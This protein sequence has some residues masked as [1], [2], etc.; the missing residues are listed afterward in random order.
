MLYDLQGERDFEFIRGSD[1]DYKF[2]NID[3]SLIK[4]KDII[5]FGSATAF[6]E[7]ELKESYFK[8]LEYAEENNIFISFYPNY[9]DLLIKE[10]Y[11]DDYIENCKHFI[12]KSDFIKFSLEE[13]WLIT[14][15]K[16]V[17][18]ALDIVHKLGGKIVAITLGKRE[19]Y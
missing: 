10:E 15:E 19:L 5:H 9:R 2:D 4:A 17:D 16:Q 13:L 1:G 11:V 18:K 8:F 7:G 12:G 3:L 6:L 14:G